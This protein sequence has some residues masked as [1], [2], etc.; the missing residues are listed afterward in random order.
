MEK[1]TC[2]FSYCEKPPVVEHETDF[3]ILGGGMGGC[4]AAFEACAWANPKKLKITLVDKAATDRS[5]AVAQGLS[6]I[7]T[8]IG[9]N[10]L[11]D[12]VRYVR[13][14]LMGIIRDIDEDFPIFLNR[15]KLDMSPAE[16][17][18]G[19]AAGQRVG[20][21]DVEFELAAGDRNR[22]AQVLEVR[23]SF[24]RVGCRR[25]F[26]VDRDLRAAVAYCEAHK[27][28]VSRDLFDAILKSEEEHVDFLETQLDLIEKVGLQNYLQS[29][30]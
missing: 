26:L 28:Y 19:V 22:S 3:L 2:T 17:L 11:E 30:T 13:T 27:D 10:K 24:N 21:L 25:Q 18:V 16:E 12:Y 23:A 6:A 5:G 8:Y 9:E 14:D 29:Q 1:E 15:N 7:N 20:V 4:G